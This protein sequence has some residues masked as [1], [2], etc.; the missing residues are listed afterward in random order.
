M[1]EESGPLAHAARPAEVGTVE[2]FYTDTVYSKGERPNTRLQ[3][4]R[5]AGRGS[6]LRGAAGAEIV[7]A[8]VPRC[9][10]RDRV[11]AGD[12]HGRPGLPR[13]AA[14]LPQ[15]PPRQPG[16]PGGL[17]GAFAPGGR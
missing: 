6:P 12:H 11:H 14:L 10:C 4:G 1:D 15:P 9:R 13:R 17:P 16:H 5:Q 2:N 7:Q 8:G 3:P